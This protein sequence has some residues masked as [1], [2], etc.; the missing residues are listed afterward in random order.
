MSEPAWVIATLFP[1]QGEWTEADYLA[2]GTEQRRVECSDGRIEVLGMP[3]DRHQAIAG[4]AYV[5]LVAYA[6]QTGGCARPAGI[7]VRLGPGRFREPDVVFL[8]SARLHLR[9]EEYWNGADLVVEVVSASPEDRV[10]DLV[11]KR[12][13]YAQA[14]IPEYWIVDPVEETIT[15]LRLEGD[16]YVEHVQLGSGAI[17]ASATLDGL[18]VPVDHLLRAP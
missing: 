3:T 18:T 1:S 14:G 5:A 12:R 9:G 6:Q 16:V 11:I 4:A 13:E 10:R 17:M 7:R 2:L 8:T 15:V